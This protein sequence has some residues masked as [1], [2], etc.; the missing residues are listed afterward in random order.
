MRRGNQARGEREQDRDGGLVVGAEDRVVCVLPAAVAQDG[1]DRS[2]RGDR[3]EMRA[4]QHRAVAV[5]G[6][7]HEEVAAVAAQ[8]ATCAVLLGLEAERRELRIDDLSAHALLARRAVGAAQSR[9]GVAE[10]TPLE[11]CRDAHAS[12]VAGSAPAAI[13]PERASAAPTKSR[14]SGAGRSGRDLNSGW[15][16]EAT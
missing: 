11:R 7:S 16:C 3:V 8:R 4:Q 1:L 12:R 6:D 10:P 2:V 5:P 14:N 15:N 9:E 13:P